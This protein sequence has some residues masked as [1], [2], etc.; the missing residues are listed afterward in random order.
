MESSGSEVPKQEVAQIQ[1]LVGLGNPGDS[2]VG[3]RHNAGFMVVDAFMDAVH[4]FQLN[5][6]QPELGCLYKGMVGERTLYVLKPMAFMNN[7]GDV[8]GETVRQLSLSPLELLVVSDD[9]DMELGR[10]R[11]RMK[12]S[13]GGHK[14]IGSIAEVLGTTEFPRLR[15]GIGRPRSQE[16]SIIDY[17]LAPWTS[18][19]HTTLAATIDA[20]VQMALKAIETTPQGASWK[21]EVPSSDKDNANVQG[22]PEIEKV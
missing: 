17:V 11:L 21:L 7:S 20:A 3:T 22:E 4:T 12:G 18:D 19:E 1:L 8:V 14:G 5:A 9:L 16:E 13:S 6:W 2:Y 10:L 15:M